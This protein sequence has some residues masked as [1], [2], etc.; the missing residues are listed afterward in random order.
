MYFSISQALTFAIA[1]IPMFGADTCGF[2]GNADMEL[3]TRWM[4][5]SAF[6]PYYR[7]HNVIESIP[8]EAYRWATTAEATRRVMQIRY[9]LLPYMYTLFYEAH[10]QASTVMRALAWEFPNDPS[11]AA[12][13]TQF[14]LGPSLLVTPVLVPLADTVQGVFPGVED[15]TKWYDWYTLQAVDAQPG[16]NKTLS[17]PLEHINVHVRG[18]SILPL[19]EP[20]NTTTASRMN[21][22]NLLVA[23]DAHGEAKGS[24][25]LDDGESIVQEATKSVDVSNYS[26]LDLLRKLI[27]IIAFLSS[28]YSPRSRYGKLS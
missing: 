7:N 23:L 12:V 24:L 18:G 15:G 3:C 2:A 21:P 20:G 19:Q 13:E 9:S 26:L 16:E 6:F 11:L 25:Y 1:G 10:S 22:W 5:L 28:R 27:N 14:M 8:Q 4:E 17:A